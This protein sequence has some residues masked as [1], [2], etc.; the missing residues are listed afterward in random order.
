MSVNKVF[1]LGRVGKEPTSKELSKGKICSFTLATERK[2]KKDNQPVT[3][4]EWHN[5]VTFQ[6][7]AEFASTYV[8]KGDTVYVEGFL[9][10]RKWTDKQGEDRYVTEVVVNNIQKVNRPKQEGKSDSYDD[11]QAKPSYDNSE[12]TPF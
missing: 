6:H 2:Y 1:L 11:R 7:A 9:Q 3:E 10:T 8:N 12:D 5:V 4:T